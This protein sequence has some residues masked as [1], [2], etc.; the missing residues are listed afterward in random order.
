[1]DNIVKTGSLLEDPAPMPATVSAAPSFRDLNS[2]EM[3]GRVDDLRTIN[4]LT[5]WFYLTREWLLLG[6]I[7]A[8]TIGFY[9]CRESWGL[10][11]LWNVPVTFLAAILVGACQHRLTN[12]AHEA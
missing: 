1:M 3:Q 4:N 7:L 2:P 12:L 6:S 8:L 11:W 9:E 5:N 10:A